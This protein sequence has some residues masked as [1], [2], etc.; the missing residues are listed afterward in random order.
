MLALI[1]SGVKV[2]AAEVQLLAEPQPILISGP[3]RTV[4]P[5]L[6]LTWFVLPP[7]QIPNLLPFPSAPQLASIRRK[8]SEAEAVCALFQHVPPEVL[9]CDSREGTLSRGRR[10]PPP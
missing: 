6:H 7:A 10:F 5:R 3:A 8:W 4:T 9:G 1:C 2:S